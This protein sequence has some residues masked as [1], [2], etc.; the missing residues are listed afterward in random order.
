MSAIKL[1]PYIFFKGNCR[2]VMEFYK[3]IFGG[4]LT[5]RTYGDVNAASEQTPAEYIMHAALDNGEI[6][7]M[8]SDTAQ[9]SEKAA[10]VTLSVGGTDEQKLRTIF[11]RLSEDVTVTYPL[12]KEFWGDIFGNLTDKFGVEWMVNITADK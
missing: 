6:T 12:K 8:A 7:I 1:E 11:D 2:E 5:L 10:K 9:A 3:S 4:E